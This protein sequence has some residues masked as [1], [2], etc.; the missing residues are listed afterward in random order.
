MED[1]EE[2][3]EAVGG[4]AFDFTDGSCGPLSDWVTVKLAPE[5]Y[6]RPYTYASGG[7]IEVEFSMIA[8]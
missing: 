3:F 6:V 5:S 1:L 8:A 4:D 2:F 7:Y